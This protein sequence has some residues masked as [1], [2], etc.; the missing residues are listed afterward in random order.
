[1]ETISE[2]TDIKIVVYPWNGKFYGKGNFPDGDTFEVNSDK[3]LNYSGWSLLVQTAWNE[4]NKPP[5]PTEPC[6]CPICGKSFVCPN[7]SL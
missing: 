3:D 4:K 7:R 6:K 1:M 2:L 5:L